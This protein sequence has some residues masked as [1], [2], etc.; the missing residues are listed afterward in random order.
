M[1]F[2]MVAKMA[3]LWE[4]KKSLTGTV[5][6]TFAFFSL[7]LLVAERRA[8]HTKRIAC[9]HRSGFVAGTTHRIGE[10]VR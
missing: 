2:I 5:V 9:D 6:M 7:S 4:M 10:S 8:A 1:K 3:E